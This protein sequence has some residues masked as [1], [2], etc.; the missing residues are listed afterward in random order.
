MKDLFK[1]YK[2]QPKKL[3]KITSKWGDKLEQKGYTFK[4]CAKFLEAANKIGYTFSYELD[5]EPYNLRL[6]TEDEKQ[7]YINEHGNN[8]DLYLL[9]DTVVKISDNKYKNQETQHKTVFTKKELK[10]FFKKEYNL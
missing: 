6:M 9:D 7:E 1:H 4:R 2:E 8:F 10:E 5:A 3:R